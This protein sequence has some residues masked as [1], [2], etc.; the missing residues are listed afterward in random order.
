VG[1]EVT[2]TIVGTVK[3]IE[4]DCV[5]V[6]CETINDTGLEEILAEHGNQDE[7]S[8]MQ[9]LTSQADMGG[10]PLGGGGGYG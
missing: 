5:Y 1:D 9:R 2:V 3:S 6:V 10:V 7:D 4:N 8:M